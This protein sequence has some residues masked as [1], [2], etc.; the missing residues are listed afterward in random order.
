MSFVMLMDINTLFA[1][2]IVV[3]MYQANSVQ[4]TKNNT[5]SVFQI[6]CTKIS[7]FFYY[8]SFMH[9]YIKVLQKSWSIQFGLAKVQFIASS[10]I[11][12]SLVTSGK[13]LS[14]HDQ[15]GI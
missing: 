13:P 6:Y 1:I 5:W 9:V 14:R 7:L 2:T 10:N 15:I 4:T 11:V 3:E 12:Y 8:K